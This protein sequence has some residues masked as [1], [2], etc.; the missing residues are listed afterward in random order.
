MV[1]SFPICTLLRWVMFRSINLVIWLYFYR[2]S[3]YVLA[4][5]KFKNLVDRLTCD[6]DEE[7]IWNPREDRHNASLFRGEELCRNLY[8]I[9]YP[10]VQFEQV[11]PPHSCHPKTKFL[12]TSHPP[13]TKTCYI[14]YPP[15]KP[16]LYGISKMHL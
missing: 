7:H 3:V 8:W 15:L 4:L 2:I 5:L 14:L 10:I 9:W 13:N 11:P 16:L 6:D 1:S 12:H